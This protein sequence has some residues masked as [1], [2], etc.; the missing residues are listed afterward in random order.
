[1]G[2]ATTAQR[3]NRAANAV[4]GWKARD[5]GVSGMFS[6]LGLVHPASGGVQVEVLVRVN[7]EM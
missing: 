6:D 1:M 3:L 4:C 5:V 2:G 7:E